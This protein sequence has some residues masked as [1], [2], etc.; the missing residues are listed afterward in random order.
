MLAEGRVRRGLLALRAW[1]CSIASPVDTGMA[2]GGLAREGGEPESQGHGPRKKG[3]G[4]RWAVRGKRQGSGER[5]RG[6]ASR[7]EQWPPGWQTVDSG[8]HPLATSCVCEAWLGCSRLAHTHAAWACFGAPDAEVTSCKEMAK[9]KIF[10][11]WP[12]TEKIYWL[13]PRGACPGDR[14]H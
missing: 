3:S 11:V 14:S 7:A 8:P 6:P 4:W 13:L 1:G 2:P 10:V 5:G 12:F 9:P